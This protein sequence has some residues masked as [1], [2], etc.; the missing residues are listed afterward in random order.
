[1]EHRRSGTD[2]ANARPGLIRRLREKM[3]PGAVLHYGQGKWYPGEPLPRW[4]M[5]CSWRADGVAV[6]ENID[7]IA[8]EE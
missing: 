2:Q 7:L 6:W 3:A 8:Q 1:M 4:A 5:S